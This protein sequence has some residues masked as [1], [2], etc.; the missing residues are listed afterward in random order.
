MKVSESWLRE[1]IGSDLNIKEL[2]ESL[3]MSGLKVN[4]LH[5]AANYFDGV[6]IGNIIACRQHFIYNDLWIIKVNIGDD[7]PLNIVCSATNCTTHLKVV[8][9]KSGATITGKKKIKTIEVHGYRSE[10]MLCSFKELGILNSGSDIIILPDDA[11]IGLDFRDYL[12]FDD[13]VIDISIPFNRGDCLGLL[14][15]AR[16][17]TIIN[18]LLLQ[19][20]QIHSIQPIINDILPIHVSEPNACPC[21]LG[22]I[23][24]NI[25]NTISI[26]LW[27]KERLRRSGICFINP[28]MDIINYVS[29]ELGYPINAFDLNKISGSVFVRLAK[30]G[31]SLQLLNNTK[32]NIQTDTLVI[33]DQKQ[34]LAI[35]GIVNGTNSIVDKS[36]CSILLEC[37]FF[38]SS[39]LIGKAKRYGLSNALSYR[40]ERGIDPTLTKKVM[41]RI[42]FFL[43]KI[44]GAYPGPILNVTNLNMLPKLN[45]I[46]LHKSKLNKLIGHFISND[47]INNILTRIG[48]KVTQITKDWRISIPYW[49]Y[50]LKLEEDLIEEII[51]IY[52]YDKLPMSSIYS[53]LKTIN[54]NKKQF[55]LLRI[56]NLLV[57]RGYQEVITYSF[58]NPIIQNLLFPQKKSLKIANPT[59][60]EMSVMRLSLWS[61]LISTIIYNQNRQQQRMKLFE[62]GMVFFSDKNE[63]WKIGQHFMLSG[64]ITGMRY[65]EYWDHKNHYFMDFY[66]IKG[67]VE[68]ILNMTNK[69][70]KIEF[71]VTTNTALH[72]GQSAGI[73]LK[74][75]CIGFLGLIHPIL[76][77]QLNLN[78]HTLVF[79]IFWEKISKTNVSKI[80][81]VTRFPINRRDIN[82]IVAE[83]IAGGDVI[84]ECKIILKQE[85]INIKLL[86][87]Y[88]GNN[89]SKG[90]KSLTIS[91]FLYND[92]HTLT[93]IE[94]NEIIVKC[95]QKLRKKFQASLKT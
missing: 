65:E 60:I 13:N 70:N 12:K 77:K 25:D 17:I 36:T 68:A 72:P 42:T 84:N 91:L 62:S 10:G 14:G 66:D 2:T 15:I 24:K 31:E 83:E 85:L 73:Y 6:I 4:S 7:N 18:K 81:N 27:M 78:S 63:P 21:Y 80:F 49:R 3:T 67:D 95:I 75:E 20:P 56:K 94:T 57:D 79:E 47:E 35:A 74:N 55:S 89:I 34:P 93:E 26:P 58:V 48:C 46:I 11:P 59:S 33:A 52:G 32:I 76:E 38:S 61:S 82:I 5:P 39:I 23:I 40:Y 16:D 28:I 90:F 37:A 30:Q 92:Y 43:V 88:R 69:I 19:K 9:A 87:V 71:K 41:E 51:R 8:V 22:R 44:C 1:W 50:D 29:L 45:M 54:I 53:T 86:D 64:I